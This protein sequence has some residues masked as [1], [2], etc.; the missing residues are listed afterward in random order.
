MAT[1][2]AESPVP[3]I[4]T[5]SAVVNV[6]AMGRESEIPVTQRT[7]SL[8]FTVR[9]KQIE[10]RASASPWGRIEIAATRRPARDAR[11]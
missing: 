5:N 3:T 10:A 9:A 1:W 6:E 7:V 4:A 11:G 2:P 8:S